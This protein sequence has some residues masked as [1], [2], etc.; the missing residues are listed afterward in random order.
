[1]KI[2][3]LTIFLKIIFGCVYFIYHLMCSFDIQ[4]TTNSFHY[5]TSQHITRKY[6]LKLNDHFRYFILPQL[7]V[8]QKSIAVPPKIRTKMWGFPGLCV[9]TESKILFMILWRTWSAVT[10]S[11]CRIYDWPGDRLPS[12]CH[13][14]S[15]M[16]RGRQI[17]A[18]SGSDWP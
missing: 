9:H 13:I 6:F 10:S 16:R 4:S 15:L 18:Q 2:K 11:F 7:Y 8:L 14:T 3:L 17:L 12:L 1:M 5:T